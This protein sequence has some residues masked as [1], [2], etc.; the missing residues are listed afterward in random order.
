ME[1]LTIQE[2]HDQLAALIE[3]GKGLW[4]VLTPGTLDDSMVLDFVTE[5]HEDTDYIVLL[6]A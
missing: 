6:H 2:L 3:Q 1:H 5:V 4:P